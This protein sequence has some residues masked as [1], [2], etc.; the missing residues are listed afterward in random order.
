MKSAYELAMERLRSEEP[1]QPLSEEQKAKVAEIDTK[2]AAKLA[3]RE[4]FLNPKIAEAQL[5]G[6]FDAV[7]QLEKQLR[8]EKAMLEDDKEREKAA[9][10]K[11]K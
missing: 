7:S 1:D 4:L 2:F 6:D 10:R 9:V 3:E 8:D 5:K 11:Q